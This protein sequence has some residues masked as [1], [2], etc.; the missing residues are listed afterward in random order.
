MNYHSRRYLLVIF[1]LLIAAPVLPGSNGNEPRQGQG[2]EAAQAENEKMK[3]LVEY[4][5]MKARQRRE[6]EMQKLPDKSE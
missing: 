4:E 6:K 2:A 5:H 1:S 3:E